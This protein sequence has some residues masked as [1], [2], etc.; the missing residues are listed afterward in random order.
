L[1]W[2]S[3]ARRSHRHLWNPWKEYWLYLGTY[4]SYMPFYL[5]H[6]DFRWF[7]SVY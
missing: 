4:I 3:V 1:A 6:F 5:K 2:K 7:C